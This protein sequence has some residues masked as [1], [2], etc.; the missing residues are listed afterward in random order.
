[1]D[2]PDLSTERDQI[3]H[4]REL[5]EQYYQKNV[6][7]QK[8]FDDYTTASA[9]LEKELETTIDQKE[10][11]VR[12]LR[13]QNQRLDRETENLKKRN[14]RL[15]QEYSQMENELKVLKNEKER[16]LSYIRELE[17]TN[18]DLE[19]TR[20]VVTESV[21]GIETLLN[22]AYERIAVLES[23]V[24]EREG[25]RTK[26]QRVTDELRD[27][28]QEL[29]VKEVV[30]NGNSPATPAVR[31]S[32]IDQNDVSKKLFNGH[33]AV[34]SNRLMETET[35]TS[36]TGTPLKC[37]VTLNGNTMTPSSRISALNIVG[38]LLRKVGGLESKLAS[39]RAPTHTRDS[40]HGSSDFTRDPYRMRRIGSRGPSSPAITP[41][42][43][44]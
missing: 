6:D 28:K 11:T 37:D 22:Q 42:Y 17:Q 30:P 35:Q 9:Q 13:Q 15:Q 10:K 32:S 18:D 33:I 8:E 44:H 24:E 38:D 4:Y 36:L 27:V 20:R 3:K 40:S 41:N 25:L 31:K 2:P 1:M 21:A 14:D 16:H 43:I 39:C 26:L 5:A 34:D 7:L 19:R 12:E 29:Y 23:E